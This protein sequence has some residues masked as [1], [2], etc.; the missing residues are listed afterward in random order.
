[1]KDGKKIIFIILIVV[2]VLITLLVFFLSGRDNNSTNNG[3][4]NNNGGTTNVGG[5]GNSGNNGNGGSNNNGGSSN[6]GNGNN[7]G[8]NGGDAG[9]AGSNDNS[10]S[11]F[12]QVNKYSEFFSVQT[13]INNTNDI[14]T[15]YIAKEMY[16]S[17]SDNNHFYFIDGS[18]LVND[19][20]EETVDYTESVIYLVV[21]D[22]ET[23]NYEVTKLVQSINNLE[24][25]AKNFKVSNKEIKNNKKFKMTTLSTEKLIT[26]YI[27]YFKYMLV[28]DTKEAYNMLYTTT[29]ENYVDYNDFYNQVP[30]IYN[31]LTSKLFSYST[32]KNDG[33]NKYAVEDDNRNRIVIYEDGVM[34][35]KISYNI[36]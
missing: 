20:G 26:T 15:S 28:L 8:T 11:K 3:G 1:M 30:N 24:S 12:Y 13:A 25:Y 17:K 16:V 33:K 32:M 14:N 19:I 10:N 34:N 31:K 27:E 22:T 18:L 23:Q 7:N 6:N 2:C 29:K 36:L 35:F 9:S 5:N 21:I 4:I